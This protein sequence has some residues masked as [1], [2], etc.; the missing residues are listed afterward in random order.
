MPGGGWLQIAVEHVEKADSLLARHPEARSGPWVAITV[1][2]RGAGMPM[3]VR[4]RAFEPFFTTKETGRGSGLGLSQVY[5]F[6]RQSDG[7]VTLDSEID[8][9]TEITIYLPPSASAPAPKQ[10]APDAA[11]PAQGLSE[12]ILLVEDDPAVLALC[13]EM[14]TD[15]GYRVKV[16]SDADGAL[17]ILRRRD[18]VD[19]LF[20]D[21]VMPGG[22]NGVQLASE[23]RR[24]QRNI[25]VLLTSGYT[26]EDLARQ[27]ADAALP[28]IGKPYRQA[29]LAAKL[30]EVLGAS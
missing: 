17:E 19:L 8:R 28:M 30:R 29:E 16:A 23:A 5:G 27:R 18:P 2:D 21:V 24:L 10:V 26:G 9:G 25:K 3:A 1:R 4:E 20:T 12:S 13:I 6:V 15:L 11:R 14:L 22:R 7:F